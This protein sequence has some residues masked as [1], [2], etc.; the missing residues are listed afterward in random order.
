MRIFYQRQRKTRAFLAIAHY[1]RNASWLALS[2]F[3]CVSLLM[4]RLSRVRIFPARHRRRVLMITRSSSHVA[5]RLAVDDKLK[6]ESEHVAKYDEI[7]K[8]KK[9]RCTQRKK[10]MYT[11]VRK[12]TFGWCKYY[13]Y[14]FQYHDR[15]I[16]IINTEMSF[17]T[18]NTV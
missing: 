11:N 15:R 2:Y 10:Q 5:Y 17:L 6:T 12:N 3:D 18:K 7:D 16:S 8:K 14:F 4:T 9:K 1:P 13:S